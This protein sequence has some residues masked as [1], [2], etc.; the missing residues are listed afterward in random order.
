VWKT[1]KTGTVG[2]VTIQFNLSSVPGSKTASDLRLLI[3]RNLSGTFADETTGGGG[4]ISG[5][6]DLGGGIFQ[7]SGITFNHNELFTIGTA[8]STTPLPITLT[9][10]TAERIGNQVNIEWTTATETNNDHFTIDK[11]SDGSEFFEI[12]KVAGAGNSTTPRSYNLI[13]PVALPGRSF[14]RLKQTDFDGR[15]T[16]SKV[17]MIQYDASPVIYPN[18]ATR[19]VNLDLD[20]NEPFAAAIVNAL[21]QQ[22]DAKQTITNGR[23]SWN[24]QGL[25]RG[26]YFIT[27]L[28]GGMMT[29][30][31]LVL[32]D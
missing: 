28:R 6:T 9:S 24:V 5:A 14:Y 1:G 8:S 21:G 15:F 10:L 31:K 23:V 12:G 16:I 32:A 3:D 11:S 4:V 30:Q 25:P 19:E 20:S 26:I 29:T 2:A 22:V 7:F 17:V 18:P 27:I 13:D